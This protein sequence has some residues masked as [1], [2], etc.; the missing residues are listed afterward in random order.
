MPARLM[1]RII[2]HGFVTS[3]LE[4]ELVGDPPPGVAI[5]FKPESLKGLPEEL[6]SLDVTQSQPGPVDITVSF[7][8]HDGA[9]DLGGRDR[10]HFLM[11]C[12]PTP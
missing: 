1:A 3:R 4:A 10:I 11:N 8:A 9:R 5:D 12:L 2:N 6:R 7:R